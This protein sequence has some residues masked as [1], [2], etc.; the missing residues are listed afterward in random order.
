MDQSF[1]REAP[2]AHSAAGAQRKP[3]RWLVLIDSGGS[4]VARLFLENREPAGEFDAGTEAVGLMV[5]GLVPTRGALG[6]EW[7][8]PLEGHSRVER[9]AAE[10]YSLDV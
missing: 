9:A 10:V 5:Q 3:A 7:D 4:T 6:A 1:G 8:R 2:A